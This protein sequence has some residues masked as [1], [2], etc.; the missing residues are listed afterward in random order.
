M[1]ILL[2]I[3]FV[4]FIW[5]SHDPS[6]L[7]SWFRLFRVRSPLLAE[8]LFCFL[9]LKVLRCFNSLR[10]L[11]RS[12]VFTSGS[13]LR[14]GLPHSD[15]TGSKP[16]WRLADTFRSLTRPSSLLDTKASSVRPYLLLIRHHLP[17]LI[18]T[19]LSTT[20]LLLSYHGN[21][22]WKLFS[23]VFFFRSTFSSLILLSNN[24][25]F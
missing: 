25:V 22:L 6:W 13:P 1:P 2:I 15:I 23:I 20:C 8:S 17:Y 24:L 11:H 5:L 10:S 4:T 14:V 18:A 12:Y 19:T 7:A 3:R 16:F 21:T 9:F